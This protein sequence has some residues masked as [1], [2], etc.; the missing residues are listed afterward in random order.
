MIDIWQHTTTE[1]WPLEKEQKY[2]ITILLS[3]PDYEIEV[4]LTADKLQMRT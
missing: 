1:I 3:L 2:A 4:D